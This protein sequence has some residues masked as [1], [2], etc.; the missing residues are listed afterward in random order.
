MFTGIGFED[1]LDEEGL[2]VV[3]YSSL[4]DVTLLAAI[5]TSRCSLQCPSEQFYHEVQVD[6]T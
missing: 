3:M 6:Y 4:Q 2:V 1:I 5:V